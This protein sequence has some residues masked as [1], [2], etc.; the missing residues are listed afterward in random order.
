MNNQQHWNDWQPVDDDL[1]RLLQPGFTRRTQPQQPLL[2]LKKALRNNLFWSL[3]ITLMY[4]ILMVYFQFWEIQLALFVTSLFNGW[5]MWSAWKLYRQIDKTIESQAPLL[6]TLKMHH[7]EIS[8]WGRV[9]LKLALLVYPFSVAGGYLLGGIVATGLPVDALMSQK[10][11]FWALPVT[12]IVLVP[13]SYLL[14]RWL[15]RAAFGVHLDRLS[16]NIRE[17]ESEE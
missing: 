8:R 11:F 6:E 13:V 7:S 2:K 17:L 16:E 9:Q 3:G 1:D 14:A 12:I 4:I 10:R 15:F 5:L